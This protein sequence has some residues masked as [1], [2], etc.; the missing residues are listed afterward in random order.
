LDR[1]SLLTAFYSLFYWALGVEFG[2]ILAKVLGTNNME[3]HCTFC[4]I[5]LIT[6]KNIRA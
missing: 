4:G 1:L 3:M 6:F 5:E 2:T